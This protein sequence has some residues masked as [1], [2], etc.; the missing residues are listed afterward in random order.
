MADQDVQLVHV[1]PLHEVEIETV[2]F[3]QMKQELEAANL[4]DFDGKI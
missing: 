2:S 3:E 4:D 1:E